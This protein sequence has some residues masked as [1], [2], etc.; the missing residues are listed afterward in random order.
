[1]VTTQP[2]NG[3]KC[4]KYGITAQKSGV[5][6]SKSGVKAQ[7]YEVKHFIVRKYKAE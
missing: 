4:S 6:T 1:M 3:V 2:V 5:N 7:K